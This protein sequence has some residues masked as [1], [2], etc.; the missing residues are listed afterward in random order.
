MVTL[1]KWEWFEEWKD[2]R[3]M[4][5]GEDYE[6]VKNAIGEHMWEQVLAILPQLKDKVSQTMSGIFNYI[7]TCTKQ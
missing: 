1:A 5:R 4:K 6:R 7:G 2:G 3:V